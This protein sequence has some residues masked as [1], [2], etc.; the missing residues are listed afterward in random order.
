MLTLEATRL[1]PVVPK[2]HPVSAVS[3]VVHERV[4]HAAGEVPPGLDLRPD[5]AVVCLTRAVPPP[6]FE[7]GTSSL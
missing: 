6:G 7:P 3:R 2:R 4:A 1:A 5:P